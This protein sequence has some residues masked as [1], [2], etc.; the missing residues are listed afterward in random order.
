MATLHKV[1]VYGTL[2]KGQPN[3]HHMSTQGDFVSNFIS[4]ARTVERRPLIIASDAN[5]PMILD[6]E[7]GHVSMLF[8]VKFC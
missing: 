5:V 7:G 2:K 6:M 4:Y 3:E 1:F 8:F